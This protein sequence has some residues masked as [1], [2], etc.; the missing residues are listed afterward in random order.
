MKSKKIAWANYALRKGLWHLFSQIMLPCLIIASIV[1]PTDLKAQANG[2]QTY[3][4]DDFQT[5]IEVEELSENTFELEIS[6]FEI[7]LPLSD[8]LE[9]NMDLTFPVNIPDASL[10][11]DL[12]DTWTCTSQNPPY[13]ISQSANQM[14]LKILG[15][16]C[17]GIGGEGSVARITLHFA[18]NPPALET[19]ESAVA[20]GIVIMDDVSMKFNGPLVTDHQKPYKTELWSFDGKL[21]MEVNLNSTHLPKGFFIRRMY[22]KNGIVK[23]DKLLIQ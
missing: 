12:E 9:L 6:L 13:T 3:D 11:V 17:N 8:V 5:V 4:L 20:G 16:N 14:N 18:G 1:G 21:V 22:Y 15:W 19:L 2:P 7:A 23:T 10:S